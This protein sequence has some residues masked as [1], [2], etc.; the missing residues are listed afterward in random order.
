MCIASLITIIAASPSSAGPAGGVNTVTFSFGGFLDQVDESLAGVFEVGDPFYGSL[1]YDLDAPDQ[2][3]E[4]P[5]YG[6]YQNVVAFSCVINGTHHAA[7]TGG[8]VNLPVGNVMDWLVMD[9]FSGDPAADMTPE[10]V[11]MP[12]YENHGDPLLTT[13]V[14][15]GHPFPSM[16]AFGSAQFRIRFG[17]TWNENEVSG[18]I[19][20]DGPP[21]PVAELTWGGIKA[22]YAE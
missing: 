7:A 21:T 18:A 15:P 19:T 16:L 2:L 17:P 5:D 4:N 8:S 20:L 11:N 6:I 12:L 1:T 3:P 22:V 14:M 13:D 10:F 9:G